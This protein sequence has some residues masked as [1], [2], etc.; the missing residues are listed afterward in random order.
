METLP[1]LFEAAKLY[2]SV[3][4]CQATYMVSRFFYILVIWLEEYLSK[5][6]GV[7]KQVTFK[8]KELFSFSL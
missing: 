1:L 8:N 5:Q 2:V 7:Y 6:N 4:D 3:I